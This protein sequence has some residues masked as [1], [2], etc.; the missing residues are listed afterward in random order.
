MKTR[1]GKGAIQQLG[2]TQITAIEDAA[3]KTTGDQR[4]FHKMTHGEIAA[5]ETGALRAGLLET[6]APETLA[7]DVL[8]LLQFAQ[9]IFKSARHDT[10]HSISDLD[11]TVSAAVHL[12]HGTRDR[13][14]IVGDQVDGERSDVRLGHLLVRPGAPAIQ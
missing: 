10:V 11:N 1:R 6:K 2:V 13:F 7:G 14:R 4:R 8:P 9:D 5:H 12:D 3:L